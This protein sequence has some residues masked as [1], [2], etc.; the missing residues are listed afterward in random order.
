MLYS[1]LILRNSALLVHHWLAYATKKRNRAMHAGMPSLKIEISVLQG[2]ARRGPLPRHTAS[3]VSP[4]TGM[5]RPVYDSLRN[6]IIV[7]ERVLLPPIV[8]RVLPSSGK[9]LC[10]SLACTYL[11]VTVST[12]HGSKRGEESHDHPHC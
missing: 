2:V 4:L 5:N 3:K 7:H 1:W 6:K 11:Q 10:T 8:P 9:E 12:T